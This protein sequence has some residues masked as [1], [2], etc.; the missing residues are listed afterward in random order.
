MKVKENFLDFFPKFNF[1]NSDKYTNFLRKFKEITL[2]ENL[3]QYFIEE[4][5]N[6]E[7]IEKILFQINFSEEITKESQWILINL[8]ANE[9]IFNCENINKIL[10]IC[11]NHLDNLN[12]QICSQV[13]I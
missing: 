5:F 8:T 10:E 3:P 12:V 6:N 13:K 4:F 9:I 1:E 7:I 11:L 2:N